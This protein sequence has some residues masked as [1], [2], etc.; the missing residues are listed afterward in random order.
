MNEEKFV[1]LKMLFCLN[2]SVDKKL[3]R[4]LGANAFGL[5]CFE[6]YFL[7]LDI[8]TRKFSQRTVFLH[9]WTNSLPNYAT[10]N[11]FKELLSFLADGVK[12]SFAVNDFE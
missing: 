4:G 7:D 9:L 2:W 5:V 8:Q 12:A 10:K 1:R 11:H 3:A 6:F